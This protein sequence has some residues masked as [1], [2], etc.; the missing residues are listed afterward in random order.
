MNPCTETCIRCAQA[1]ESCANACLEEPTV[2]N[3]AGCIRLARDCADLCWTAAAMTARSSDYAGELC[4]LCAEV[5]YACAT[6]CEL[7]EVDHCQRCAG[8]CRLC[9]EECRQMTGASA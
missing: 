1:C 5:C 2:A 3:M 9:A 6:E 4:R 8:E 7:F